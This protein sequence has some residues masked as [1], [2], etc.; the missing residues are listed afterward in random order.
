MKVITSLTEMQNLCLQ[1][2]RAGKS[3]GFVPTMG[4]LHEGHLE[5]MT[6]A[7]A[8]NDILLTSVFVNPLQFGPN[9][10]FDKYPRDAAGDEAKANSVG[11]DYFF[12]PH[13]DDMYPTKLATTMT[14]NARTDV[15]CG[16]SRP[17]HF[18]GVVTVLAKLFNIVLPDHVYMG[19]KD[20]QQVAVVEQF[21]ADYNFPLQ[22]IPVPTVRERDGLAKSSRNVYLTDDERSLAPKLY[23]SLTKAADRINNGETC[24]EKIVSLVKQ[25]LEQIKETTIDYVDLYHYPSLELVTTISGQIIIA[26]AVK[27]KNARLID[28][29]II[30]VDEK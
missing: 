5:L 22:I 8:E 24:P 2:K 7:R 14:V 19:T 15:L 27:F 30:E 9:E 20:A 17:G 1:L 28:N 12:Y 25:E 4:Y 3:I 13:V 21:V 10:D 26:L 18:D 11:V 29:L 6:V 16:A 23:A